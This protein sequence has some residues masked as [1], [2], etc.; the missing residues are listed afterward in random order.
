[1]KWTIS[2][3]N[4]LPII[5]IEIQGTSQDNRVLWL[6][7]IHWDNPKCNLRLL[8]KHLDEAKA[9]NAPI[10][11]VGDLFCAMQGKY[12]KRSHK[13]DLRAEHQKGNY[14]DKLWKTAAKWFE[15]YKNLITVVG[16]GNHETA[17]LERHESDLIENFVEALGGTARVGGYHGW[18]KFN[19]NKKSSTQRA[20]WRAY[21]WHGKRGG[22]HGPVTKGLID[23][24]RLGERVEA[25][26]YVLGHIHEEVSTS[27]RV[28]FV[29]SANRQDVKKRDFIRLATYKQSGEGPLGFDVERGYGLPALG[30][31]WM[32]IKTSTSTSGNSTASSGTYYYE[33]KWLDC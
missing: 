15:P 18:L 17:I 5:E 20:N 9:I 21:Y 33:R 11:I 22:S 1:M 8:K 4:E 2:G 10:I 3:T 16:Y 29:N 31:K 7:D 30:G 24:A 28:L 13:D 32:I 19:L 27:K 23:F 14:L 12:D 25:D 26:I 6:A